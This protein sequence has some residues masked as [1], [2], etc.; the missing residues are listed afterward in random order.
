MVQGTI[1]CK[2]NNGYVHYKRIEMIIVINNILR[3]E[4]IEKGILRFQELTF[5]FLTENASNKSFFHSYSKRT[6]GLKSNKQTLLKFDTNYFFKDC[7]KI[8]S[9]AI[10]L[11]SGSSISFSL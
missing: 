11:Y 3:I 9:F 6:D 8:D 7:L 5:P 4:K 10:H 1:E 2:Q